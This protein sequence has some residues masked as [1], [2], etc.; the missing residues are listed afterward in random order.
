M[1]RHADR[2]SSEVHTDVWGPSLIRSLGGKTYYVS[3]TDDKT[4]YMHLY[5]LTQKS[6][7]FEAYLGFKA[8]AWTQHNAKIL[9][10]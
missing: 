7:V 9:A 5:L 10:L 8:W 2:F 4:R 3:F 1:G 6:G